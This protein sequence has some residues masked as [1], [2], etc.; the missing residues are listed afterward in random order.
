[1]S[2][3]RT[4]NDP[5]DSP[6][7]HQGR[8]ALV[9]TV[10]REAVD[11]STINDIRFV[12]G[13]YPEVIQFRAQPI[14]DSQE[15]IYKVQPTDHI[16][17]FSTFNNALVWS[18]NGHQI[19]NAPDSVGADSTQPTCRELVALAKAGYLA[20]VEPTREPSSW[21]QLSTAKGSDVA[22][23]SLQQVMSH[24]LGWDVKQL[25]QIEGRR[26]VMGS[27]TLFSETG[28]E[29]QSFSYAH[30]QRRG[31]PSQHVP[32]P[33]MDD[34]WI[35]VSSPYTGATVWQGFVRF[36]PINGHAPEP[37]Q[38]RRP[39]SPSETELRAWSY[40]EYPVAVRPAQ[41]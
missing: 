9:D 37:W 17:I 20:N 26:F 12:H 31:K 23:E 8:L 4:T 27:L 24:V 2:A 14:D 19:T 16:S 13:S 3:D 21:A 1:V 7:I 39:I 40:G 18:G 34:D 6:R 5:V 28:F 29:G 25:L 36:R 38:V 30:L 15:R 32:H 35:Q 33:L 22:A 41:K 10:D 11:T